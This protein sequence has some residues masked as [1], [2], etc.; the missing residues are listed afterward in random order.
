MS[1]PKTLKESIHDLL[2]M[3]KGVGALMSWATHHPWGYKSLG[4]CLA[5]LVV[6]GLGLLTPQTFMAFDEKS[7]TLT[8]NL[9]PAAHPERRVVIVDIDEKSVQALGAWPWSRTTMSKLVE[10]LNDYGVGLK[11]FDVVMPD[12]KDGDDLLIKSLQFGAPSIGGQVFSIDPSVPVRGGVLAGGDASA[13]C[14][15]SVQTAYGFIGNAAGVANA[16]QSVGHLTPV[17]DPDGAVRKVPAWVCFESQSYPSLS[18][19]A[20]LSLGQTGLDTSRHAAGSFWVKGRAVGEAPWTLKFKAVP[21]FALPLNE[22]GQIRV[23]YRLA[24]SD[25]V[26][27]SAV[28]VIEHK[29]P[30][31][32]LGGVWALVGSTA[33]GAGDAIPTPHGGAVGGL[34]V[35]AQLIS[36]ALDDATPFTPLG[37]SAAQGVLLLVSLLFMVGLAGMSS[38]L[39]AQTGEWYKREWMVVALPFV[40]LGLCLGFY[41]LH[42]VALLEF[43]YWMP[44]SWSA[45]VLGLS[46]LVLCAEHLAQLRWQRTR[47]YDNMSRFLSD[48]VAK[49]VALGAKSEEVIA[50]QSSVI[51]MSVNLRNF[52]RFCASQS[53]ALSAKLLHQYLFMMNKEI[54]SVG[55][56][57]EHIQGAELMAVWR[58]LPEDDVLAGIAQLPQALWTQSQKWLSVW[59]H[60]ESEDLRHE[61]P[62]KEVDDAKIDGWVPTTFISESIRLGRELELEMGLEFGEALVGSMGPSQRRVNAVLGEPVQ[63]AH[64]LRAMCS[65]L[66]YPA[67]MGPALVALLSERVES[68][69]AP[70]RLKEIKLGDFLLSG[71]TESRVIY[72]CGVDVKGARLHLVDNAHERL[73]S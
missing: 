29:V 36:A 69:R 40:G 15:A 62:S 20:L 48:S 41:A 65:D 6:V 59:A 67:L 31:D 12:A 43:N 33:F 55:A 34:E 50:R 4:V 26:S 27:L 23:S 56:E 44:W 22:Q 7:D 10:A 63:V 68:Q 46:S 25:F 45:A 19:A 66:A 61:Q 30:K 13:P 35:H 21:E 14:A 71:L 57:L 16:F 38:P 8:W 54:R 53:P 70:E 37:S 49:E 60:T 47:L 2:T 64:S 5:T 18:V 24:R 58:A 32:L 39:K 11:L 9:S 1:E 17:I 3:D 51:V 52:D 72:A 28:D 42:V 73:A